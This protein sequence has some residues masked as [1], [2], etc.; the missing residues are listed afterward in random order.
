MLKLQA[1]DVDDP[2]LTQHLEDAAYRVSAVAKAHERIHQSNDTDRLDL[3]VYIEQVCRDLND[4]VAN[5]TIKV[6]AEH[7]IDILTD[8]AIPIALITNELITNAAKYAYSGQPGG[9]IQVRLARGDDGRIDL[10]IRDQGDGLPADFDPRSAAG[11]GMRIIRAFL[12]QLGAQ[13]AVR[14]RDP[15]TE[16]VVSVPDDQT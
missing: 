1:S 8:R 4:A 9:N 2:K 14:R 3:G 5:C 6:E 13:I 10:S 16:F 11:L 15:G 12:Q 7:G